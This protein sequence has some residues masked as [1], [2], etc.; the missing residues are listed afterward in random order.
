MRK[1]EKEGKWC[2]VVRC[3]ALWADGSSCPAAMLL[4]SPSVWQAANHSTRKQCHF[5]SVCQ[6]R[7]EGGG[8]RER[9]QEKEREGGDREGRKMRG[10]G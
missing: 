7:R 6:S 8:R 4:G 10:G 2:A 5:S 3:G 9:E 1:D